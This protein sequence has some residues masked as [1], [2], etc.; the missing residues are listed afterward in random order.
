VKK[1]I[2]IL[3]ALAGLGY[4]WFHVHRTNA[5]FE[6]HALLSRFPVEEGSVLSIDVG[7]L[8]KA[9]LMTGSK[10][11]LEADYKQFLDGTGFDYRRDLDSVT[12]FF[13]DHGN[14]YIARGRFNWPKMREYVVKQGGSCY[15]QLC[16]VQGSTPDRHI[17]FLPLRDDALA[18]AVSTNDLAATALNNPGQPIATVLPSSPVWLSIP[19]AELR[20]PNTLPAGLRLMLSAL[21]TAD[22][23]VVTI[24]PG[25]GGIEARLETVCKTPVD[26]GVL[27][28]QLRTTT[29][30]LKEALAH[31]KE[32][33]ND[34]LAAML[35][36][37]TFDQSD[38]KVV[39]K[40]P[41]NKN[42]IEFLTTGM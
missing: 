3:I 15:Q 32:A 39:G 30:T 18:L 1:A 33:Q 14:Y 16:R 13:S 34:D 31:D 12:A 26:A 7:L 28:S 6:P 21:Q 25:A 38:R 17:S 40:W 4:I 29:A 5:F 20:R 19:G 22:R 2:A 42:L 27:T 35:M 24:G 8:R 9:G 11:P 37:G 10:A 41:V 36:A 23:I